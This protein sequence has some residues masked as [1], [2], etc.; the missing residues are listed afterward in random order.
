[1][2]RIFSVFVLFFLTACLAPPPVD[3]EQLRLQ[4]EQRALEVKEERMKKG[5]ET[6]EACRA[7]ECTRLD[8]DGA[9]LADFSVLNDMPH[10]TKLMMSRTNFTD[11]GQISG[12]SQLKELHISWTEVDDLTGLAAFANLD[13][14]HANN[15]R[16]DPDYAPV[17]RM[18]GLKELS[19]DARPA[20]GIG[21][22]RKMPKLEALFLMGGQVADFGPLMGNRSIKHLRVDGWTAD[23]LDPLKNMRN[24]RLLDT[25]T[26]V[27][28]PGTQ[29]A[30]EDRGVSVVY[31]ALP[32]VC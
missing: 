10:V 29:A 5:A 18:R 4:Q 31:V 8:L 21:F 11:L 27:L 6:L 3:P 26:R 19:L 15:M 28:D 1:L 9:M 14:L 13:L 30:F 16:A 17:Y 12:M 2:L 22:V 32:P 25:G 24:L 23:N 20:E 7:N